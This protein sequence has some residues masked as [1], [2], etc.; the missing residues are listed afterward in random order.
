MFEKLKALLTKLGIVIPVEKEA[1]LKVDIEKLTTDPNGGTDELVKML[2]GLKGNSSS[3]TQ[4]AVVEALGKQV[5]VL[6]EQNKNLTTLLTEEKTSREN[7]IKVQADADKAAKTKKVTDK[8]DEALKNK[9]IVEADKTIWLARL[10]K[11]FDEWSKELD[12]K[13]VPKQM[14]PKKTDSSQQQT[15]QPTNTGNAILDNIAAHNQN[16]ALPEIK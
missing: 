1:E 13:P 10:E 3:A 7:A 12:A 14:E 5:S 16:A 2:E 6:V 9:K 11:D 8:I 15:Q 4:N